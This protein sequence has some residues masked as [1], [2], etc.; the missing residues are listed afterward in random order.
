M[1]RFSNSSFDEEEVRRPRGKEEETGEQVHRHGEGGLQGVQEAGCPSLSLWPRLMNSYPP[2]SITP[3]SGL[4]IV[5]LLLRMPANS[6]GSSFPN[7]IR[8]GVVPP[9]RPPRLD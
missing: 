3:L 6:S 1:R 9:E 5:R 2:I 7:I 4:I 8:I